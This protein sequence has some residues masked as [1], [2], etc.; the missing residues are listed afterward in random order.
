MAR[1]GH[2]QQPL[3]DWLRSA[4]RPAPQ[5]TLRAASAPVVPAAPPEGMKARFIR[6]IGVRGV[7]RI[8]WEAVSV[9]GDRTTYLGG[10][11]NAYGKPGNGVHNAYTP[12]GDRIGSVP[13]AAFGKPD[14]YPDDR[15]PKACAH[16]GAAVPTL[17]GSGL[18]LVRQVF[19]SRLYDTPSGEPEP[20][21]VFWL[22]L[23]SPDPCYFWDNCSGPHLYGVLPNGYQWN[24]D[25][26]ASNCDQKDD[27]THRCW[28]RHGSPEEGAIHVD[29]AG[30][31]CGAGAGS[32]KVPGW[33][34][35][36]THGV[37]VG[38]YEP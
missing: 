36:L 34:G 7:L 38:G 12:I 28:V 33:H 26:R 15:W 35:H 14:D 13:D 27:R 24:I 9:E 10:C 22:D 21:D 30:V 29:K 16:C 5:R 18:H 37:W 11:P 17:P 25:G 1:R 31:T 32:I 2:I 8:Y 3:Q 19:T 23:H 4:A 6:E 20:G